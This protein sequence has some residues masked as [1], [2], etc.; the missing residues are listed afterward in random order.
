MNPSVFQQKPLQTQAQPVVQQSHIQSLASMVTSA[1]IKPVNIANNV[2]N[3]I[4]PSSPATSRSK[5]GVHDIP[6][7]DDAEEEI[8]QAET[9]SDYM[10]SK[11]KC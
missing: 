11:R 2:S 9:Y 5:S 10:P 6:D 7:E 8:F 1:N 4:K 3:Q